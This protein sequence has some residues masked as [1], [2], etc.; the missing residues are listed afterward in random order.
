MFPSIEIESKLIPKHLFSI[1]LI[2]YFLDFTVLIAAFVF[3]YLLRFD[4]ALS[5]EQYRSCLTHTLVVVFFQIVSLR[6]FK[7]H[8]F[9]WRYISLPE[10]TQIFQALAIAVVPIMLVR[11]FFAVTPSIAVIP[12]SVILMNFFLA[13]SGLLGIRLLRRAIHENSRCK[14]HPTKKE[15]QKSVLLIGAGRAGVMM[16]AELKSGGNP[17]YKVRGFIDDNPLKLG[18]VINGVEVIGKTRDIPRKVR[19]LNIDYVI[20]TL[21][22]ASRRDMQRIVRICESV[23]VKVKTIPGLS[24]LLDEKVSVSRIR[25]IEV[26]DLLGRSP[27]ELD[28]QSIEA[29]LSAKKVLVTG[30]GGSIGSELVRQLLRC[31]PQ[32]LILVERS[33]F[34]LFNIENE[35]NARCPKCRIVSLIADIGDGNRMQKIFEQYKPQ[36]VFHAAAHKHVPMMELNSAE[37]LKN[38]V[39]GTQTVA[40]I[41]AEAGAEA[42][43][44]ISTD[45]AV[46]PTSIMGASK[47]VAELIIQDLNSKYPTRFVAVRFGNV[48]NSNGS[49]I[50][51]FREQIKNGGPVT[52]THPE[53]E[54]FFMTIPEASQ[55]VLQAG[56]IGQG[57]EIFIL[58]M[59]E[60]V[61]ILELARETIRLSGFEPDEDIQIVYTGM[62]SGEKL[63]EELQTSKE[64]LTKTIHSK[65]FIGH[66]APFSSQKV[67]AALREIRELCSRQD[68]TAI[69]FYLSELLPEAN[70]VKN[71]STEDL[72]ILEFE[73][74]I[75]PYQSFPAR[76]TV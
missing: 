14:K 66:I 1:K 36:V 40:R 6:A 21:V 60:P 11:S 17:N 58:D 44:L 48:I 16:L 22:E 41:A 35:I 71:Q 5:A 33:E 8:R 20:I 3:A 26:E 43:V 74:E 15:A 47:R 10:I 24:E 61:K 23:P 68:E 25:D 28:K 42:F 32:E 38:N 59:G 63:T 50:P 45:K 29:F 64:K 19:E 75:T 4:F 13:A 51:I 73:K 55:L 9:I 49:V 69:R 46:N 62:R 2:Q 37:A 7:V 53:M 27:V 31:E 56:A 34:A 57:G 30:A 72:Q 76:L 67:S 65:I 54:R 18:L 12:M 70:L 39:L 52:V